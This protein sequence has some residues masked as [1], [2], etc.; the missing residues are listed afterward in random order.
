MAWV[1]WQKDAESY[2]C[3]PILKW[4]D[5]EAIYFLKYIYQSCLFCVPFSLVSLSGFLLY[6]RLYCLH[7]YLRGGGGGGVGGL[8]FCPRDFEPEYLTFQ[9]AKNLIWLV[10]V[11]LLWCYH[12]NQFLAGSCFKK[13]GNHFSK[14]RKITF[15][16]L[17]HITVGSFLE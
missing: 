10:S 9:S 14:W 2:F 16:T 4:Q 5:Q 15:L 12:K 3:F 6:Y 11:H 17:A 13:M 7:R 8:R 1:T